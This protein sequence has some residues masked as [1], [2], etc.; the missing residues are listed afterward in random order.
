MSDLQTIEVE[1]SPGRTCRCRLVDGVIP[2]I[3]LARVVPRAGGG[4][5]L[6]PVDDLSATVRLTLGLPR[7]LG[8][9]CGYNT[10]RRLIV[11][12]MIKART[13]SFKTTL[14]D[15][16]SLNEHLQRT[17]TDRGER[18]WTRERI[19]AYNLSLGPINEGV[20]DL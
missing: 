14:I 20:L 7:R 3:V 15:L 17:R 13:L 12:G 16:A 4:Y 8:I 10:F 2:Q 6:V 9:Q 18:W 19:E 1:I 5:H 11:C